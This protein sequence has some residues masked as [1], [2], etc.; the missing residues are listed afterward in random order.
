M[1]AEFVTGWL[2]EKK[3]D[4]RITC[5]G[6]SEDDIHIWDLEFT[7]WDHSSRLGIP[8]SIVEEEGALAGKLMELETGGWLDDAK[9]KDLWVL[10]AAN[11]ISAGLAQ[12]GKSPPCGR[13][14]R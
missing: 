4:A 1:A 3:P 14:E 11:H 10:V 8:D 6:V 13:S 2:E 7:G 12:F 9:G 5:I